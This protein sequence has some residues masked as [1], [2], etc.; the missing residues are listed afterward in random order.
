[1]RNSLLLIFVLLMVI[2]CKPKVPSEYIQPDDMEDILYDYHLAEAMARNDYSGDAEVKRTAYYQEVLKKHNVTE[3]EFD[4][5]LVYYYSRIDR[6]K[7]IYNRVTERL[8]NEA[9]LLGAVVDDKRF[10]QQ[11]VSG[12][13]MD[14][15]KQERD[16]LLIPYP[17]HNR[18]EFTVKADTSFRAGD[19]FTF[20]FHCEY[21]SQNSTKDAVVV[22]KA[23][24]ANDSI[25]QVSTHAN[26]AGFTQLSL[27]TN[28]YGLLKQL[29]G[30][31]Y[32]TND[33]TVTLKLMF[34]S[35]IQLMRFHHEQPEQPLQDAD[36]QKNKEDSIPSADNSKRGSIREADSD[37]TP[38]LRSGR[39]PF[40]KGGG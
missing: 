26:S 22:L 11:S 40:R 28:K 1:M 33:G 10:T 36:E 38:R 15:W 3:A 18:Y 2:G 20:Q 16:I 34:V 4:S 21:I 25:V 19:A 13:T 30:F 29:Q 37:D 14:I 9:K 27:P 23:T 24:Y 32:L 8:N 35:N 31:I 7:P 17:T 6:F 5:S 12:D 39:A